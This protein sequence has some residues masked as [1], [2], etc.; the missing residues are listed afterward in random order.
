MPCYSVYLIANCILLLEIHN[1][2][3]SVPF[4][5]QV[6]FTLTA[7][8]ICRFKLIAS[9]FFLMPLEEQVIDLMVKYLSFG[10]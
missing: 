1:L 7:Q 8:P 4:S 5:G 10:M 9:L 6:T 3:F 2:H